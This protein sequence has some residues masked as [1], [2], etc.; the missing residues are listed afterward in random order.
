[1]CLMA[2][3]LIKMADERGH[4][5]QQVENGVSEQEIRD[6]QDPEREPR[7]YQS[8]GREIRDYLLG[9]LPEDRREAIEQRIM[10]DDDFHLEVEIVEEDADHPGDGI[11]TFFLDGGRVLVRIFHPINFSVRNFSNG[12][13]ASAQYSPKYSY[14]RPGSNRSIPA[15]TEVCVVKMLPA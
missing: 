12:M 14:S 7:N 13:P 5:L 10:N 6:H 3:F 8:Y 15:G 1:M 2:E 4:V 11:T 9:T